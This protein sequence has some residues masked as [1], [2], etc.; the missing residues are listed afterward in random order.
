[1]RFLVLILN[2]NTLILNSNFIQLIPT[3]IYITH[4]RIYLGLYIGE[5]IHLLLDAMKLDGSVGE[6]LVS[7]G[8][9]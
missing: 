9:Q 8:R 2:A 5:K 4:L 7:E 3:L 6:G 1:M